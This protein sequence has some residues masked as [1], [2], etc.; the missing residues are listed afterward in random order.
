MKKFGILLL[1][2]AIFVALTVLVSCG[3]QGAQDTDSN[4]KEN[5]REEATDESYFTFYPLDDGTYAV[6]CDTELAKYLTEII[7][8][9]EHNKKAVTKIAKR[10]FSDCESLKTVIIP[11]TVTSIEDGAFEEC[12]KLTSVEIPNSV[13]NIGHSA[14]YYCTELTNIEIPDSVSSIGISVFD[15]CLALESIDVDENNQNYC[16]IEG[17]LFTKDKKTVI[18]CPAGKSESSFS[19]P[20]G[21]TT[22]CASAFALCSNLTSIAI[23]Y[24]ITSIDTYTF[25]GCSKLTS[26][27]IP[28]SVASIGEYAFDGCIA[29]ESMSLPFIGNGSDKTYLGYIF[30]ARHP[31]YNKDE[32]PES[33]KSVTVTGCTSISSDAFIHCSNL[34]N[35]IISNNVTS[36]KN[37]AFYNCSNLTIF[38]EAESKPDTWDED[39]NRSNCPVVW[40]Y[41]K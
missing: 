15:H 25:A 21:T 14:F 40:G 34:T 32:V 37:D 9:A 31:R 10:G 38:C 4:I 12:S 7:I 23:P 36:I 41:E 24:G 3:E 5:Q 26:I 1:L 33:L 11:N 13:T 22:I 27:E 18:R 19:I 2:L 20:D 28:N 35:V 30:G 8:P 6:S 39:W 17:V 16:D 29:L